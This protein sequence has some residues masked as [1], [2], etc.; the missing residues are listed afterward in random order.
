MKTLLVGLSVLL[1]ISCAPLNPHNT[2]GEDIGEVGL[3]I[4]ACPV[5]LC[6]SEYWLHEERRNE[7][8]KE[9]AAL[10]DKQAR[11]DYQRQYWAWYDTLPEAQK[12][13]EDLK[14]EA[15]AQRE[16]DRQAMRDV[17]ALQALG[18]ALSQQGPIFKPFQ[19]QP[20]YQPTAPI[21]AYPAM[22]PP[23]NCITQ[24]YGSNVRTSCY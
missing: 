15:I 5:T 12:D 20:R 23:M 16:K 7:A 17:A 1:L 4:V 22:Q 6:I 14:R 10:A 24:P 9:A 19:H 18:T 21:P 3:R 13:L 2:I 11:E 8:A